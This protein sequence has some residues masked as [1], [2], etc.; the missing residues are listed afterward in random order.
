MEKPYSVI[1]DYLDKQRLGLKPQNGLVF[2]NSTI[3]IIITIACISHMYHDDRVI[4]LQ[5][6]VELTQTMEA[7]DLDA[8]VGGQAVVLSRKGTRYCPRPRRPGF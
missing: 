6:G 3:I 2:K 1:S 4:E 8:V 5:H 7:T